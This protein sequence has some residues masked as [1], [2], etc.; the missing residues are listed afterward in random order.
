MYTDTV[1][2]H[3]LCLYNNYIVL[4]YYILY[5]KRTF[6]KISMLQS[7][8]YHKTCLYSLCATFTAVLGLWYRVLRATFVAEL[9]HFHAMFIEGYPFITA[10]TGATAD[11]WQKLGRSGVSPPLSS[12]DIMRRW[13]DICHP[14]CSVKEEIV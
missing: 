1:I 2:V 13:E 9:G 4:Q 8:Q 5:N 6:N 11:S 7:I 3:N 12:W 14:R 10:H